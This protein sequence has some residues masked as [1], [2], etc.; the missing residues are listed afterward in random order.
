[1]QGRSN[2]EVRSTEEDRRDLQGSPYEAVLAAIGWSG[3]ERVTGTG[4][5]RLATL[6]LRQA[7]D[8]PVPYEIAVRD[9]Q[10][11]LLA[12]AD[13]RDE[14]THRM[15]LSARVVEPGESEGAPPQAYLCSFRRAG[16]TDIVWALL[17][18]DF[19][20]VRRG[21]KVYVPTEV[22]LDNCETDWSPRI[23]EA[24]RRRLPENTGAAPDLPGDA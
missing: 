5:D 20:E 19:V 10:L 14:T 8:E 12:S 1:M 7:G 18:F 11:V 9:G 2:V 3:L 13:E 6:A 16:R 23:A 4:F 22:V 17:D 21:I 15:F 24:I